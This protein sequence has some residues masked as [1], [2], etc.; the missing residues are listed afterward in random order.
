MR[1]YYS[2]WIK[3]DNLYFPTNED[4]DVY[5]DCSGF[6]VV[7][8][9]CNGLA[10]VSD[11][12]KWGCI[13]CFGELIISIQYD[14]IE[15]R[16]EKDNQYYINCGRNGQFFTGQNGNKTGAELETIYDLN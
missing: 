13:N 9:Y 10:E 5:K 7:K 8:D 16:K 2:K 4:G 6:T 14:C 3:I 1:K 12:E 15:I 11:G